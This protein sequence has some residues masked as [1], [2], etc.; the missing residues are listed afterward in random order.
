[1]ALGLVL[2]YTKCSR[3]KEKP[4]ESATEVDHSPDAEY[5]RIYGSLPGYRLGVPEPQLVFVPA[6]TSKRE[7]QMSASQK[8]EASQQVHKDPC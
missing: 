8:R 7:A 5:Q 6:G 2:T 4:G 3:I 1:M